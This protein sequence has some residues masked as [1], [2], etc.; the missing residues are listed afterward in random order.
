MEFTKIALTGGPCAGKSSVLKR[1][2]ELDKP[3]KKTGYTV[4]CVS[5]TASEL[6]SGGV[7]P[8]TCGTNLDFQI[9]L[10]RLQLEKELIFELAAK[11][12]DHE[13]IVFVCDRGT[14]DGR[15]YL[16][17]GEFDSMLSSFGTDYAEQ[18]GRY[19]AVFHLL[20]AA[21][22]APEFYSTLNNSARKENPDEAVRLDDRALD[23]WGGHKNLQVI[24]GYS[25]F[26][27]KVERTVDAVASFLG[28]SE[29]LKL[30]REYY[31]DH[32]DAE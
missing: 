14:V 20:S 25:D 12:M 5:E 30:A 28:V 15:A 17:D 22:D 23:S 4:L 8:R 27:G 1:L 32:P 10:F 31:K 18:L 11:T 16:S 24:E 2:M 26:E 3:F 9:L 29:Q 19:D 13:R 6:I 21:K 7:A